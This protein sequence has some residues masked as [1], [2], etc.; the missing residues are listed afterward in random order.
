VNCDC[1]LKFGYLTNGATE[2]GQA[3]KKNYDLGIGT[4]D[5]GLT[6]WCIASNIVGKGSKNVAKK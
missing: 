4:Y 3:G 5:L 2:T 6:T 1:G